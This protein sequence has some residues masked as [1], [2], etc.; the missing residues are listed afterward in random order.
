MEPA[1]VT[2]QFPNADTARAFLTWMG[3]GGELVFTDFVEQSGAPASLT[4][5]YGPDGLSVRAAP[6]EEPQ[7][8]KDD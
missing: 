5:A 4:F 1:T 3:D 2:L 8:A 6:E 7:D